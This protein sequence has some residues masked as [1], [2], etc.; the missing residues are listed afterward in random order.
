MII[1]MKSNFRITSKSLFFVLI[2]DIFI[3]VVAVIIISGTIK[4]L[5]LLNNGSNEWNL[6]QLKSRFF[7]LYSA[8]IWQRTRGERATI[9]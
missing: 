5:F 4:N 2:K 3:V 7:I 8:L 9:C 1:I 6:E